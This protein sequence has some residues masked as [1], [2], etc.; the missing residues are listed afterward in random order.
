MYSRRQANVGGNARLVLGA[1]QT[2]WMRR[3]RLAEQ[4]LWRRDFE[5]NLNASPPTC[6]GPPWATTPAH[7]RFGRGLIPPP[8][9]L[10]E[11]LA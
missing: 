2:V 11:P 4:Y 1:N 5:L 6:A 9:P 10:V 7:H 8:S 3:G